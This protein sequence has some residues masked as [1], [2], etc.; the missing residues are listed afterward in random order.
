[1]D[2]QTASV[3][4]LTVRNGIITGFKNGVWIEDPK[5]SSCGCQFEGLLVYN[6]SYCGIYVCGRGQVVRRNH[7]VGVT[8]APVGAPDGIFVAGQANAI[9]DNDVVDVHGSPGLDPGNAIHI[10]VSTHTVIENNRISAAALEAGSAGIRVENT[11][12]ALVLHNRIFNRGFGI[13]FVGTGAAGRYGDNVTLAC[14]TPF[15]GGTDI[16]NNH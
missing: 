6:V 7:I 11:S 5:S 13:L 10:N 16:G 12:D 2:S 15:S 14:Q 1:M 3:S 4:G 9:L 8:G